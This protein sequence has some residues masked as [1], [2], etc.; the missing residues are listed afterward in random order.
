MEHYRPIFDVVFLDIEMPII[1]GMDAARKIR[2]KDEDVIIIFLTQLAQY[3]VK[4]YEVHAFDFIV[5]PVDY[6]SFRLKLKCALD[7]SGKRSETKLQVRMENGLIWLNARSVCYVE[8]AKHEITYH[9]MD[10]AYTAR[11]S[12]AE[13]NDTL[14]HEGFQYCSRYCM[15]NLRHIRGIFDWYVL[16]GDQKLEI[17][18]RR[19]RELVDAYMDFYGGKHRD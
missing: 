1:N 2:A 5:K 11:G 8:V 4:G 19:R 15:V 9:T 18:R 6:A 13:L 7:A 10:C 16:I 14:I 12:L 3:A 17:S